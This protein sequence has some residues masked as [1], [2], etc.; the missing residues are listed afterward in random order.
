MRGVFWLVWRSVG[1]TNDSLV[2]AI[3]WRV[4]GVRFENRRSGFG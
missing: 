4:E 1:I 3:K 2:S